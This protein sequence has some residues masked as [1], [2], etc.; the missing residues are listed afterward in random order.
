MS[1]KLSKIFILAAL[2]VTALSSAPSASAVTW[3][4][5]G[6]AYPGTSFNASASGTKVTLTGVSA[7]IN[8]T[9][10]DL[11]LSRLYGPTG[12][13]GTNRVADLSPSFTTCR[14]GGF[15]ATA[16]CFANSVSFWITSYAAPVASG[17]FEGNIGTVCTIYVPSLMNCTVTISPTFGTG[18]SVATGTYHDS[19]GTFTVSTSGQALTSTWSACGTLFGSA[20]GSAASTL[21]SSS[22]S[23]LQYRV[24]TSFVPNMTI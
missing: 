16:S 17:H 22:G 2:A 15:S 24:W 7:G 5:N 13:V 8:C 9:W 10:S 14:A 11:S 3:S 18:S 23:A 19:A 1:R 20:S 12:A 4:S 6:S 21:T